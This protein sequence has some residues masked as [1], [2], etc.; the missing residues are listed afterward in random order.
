MHK[1]LHENL[2]VTK[3]CTLWIPHNVTEAH[4]LRRVNWFR[5]MIQSFADG[6]SN[7][8]HDIVTGDK[9]WICYYDSE[10]KRQFAQWVFLFEDMAT[11]VKQGRSVGKKIVASF[12]GMT[13]QNAIIV[14]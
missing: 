3:L 13:G 12:F 1:I 14:L 4:K 10:T 11:K 5:E 2:A 9:S 8:V 6:D 7:A